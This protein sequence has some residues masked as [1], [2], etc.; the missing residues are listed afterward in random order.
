MQI[1]VGKERI[2]KTI[3]QYK[4]IDNDRTAKTDTL[5]LKI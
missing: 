2:M 1:S 4:Q 3:E 5:T